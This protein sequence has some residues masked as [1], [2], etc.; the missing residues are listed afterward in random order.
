MR[1]FM[2]PCLERELPKILAVAQPWMASHQMPMMLLHW[3]IVLLGWAGSLIISYLGYYAGP[4]LFPRAFARGKP[5]MRLNFAHQSVSFAHAI[6]A[7]GFSL[8]NMWWAERLANPVTGYSATLGAQCAVTVGYFLWDLFSTAA[9]LDYYGPAFMLHAIIG[10]FP[11][12]VALSPVLIGFVPGFLM[13]EVSSLFLH[14][15]WF[16]DKLGIGDRWLLKLNDAL[17]LVSFF[18]CRILFGWKLIIDVVKAMTQNR[19]AVGRL[20]FP[21]LCFTLTSSMTLNHFWFYRLFKAFIKV[22]TDGKHHHHHHHHPLHEPKNIKQMSKLE[23]EFLSD[24][25]EERPRRTKKKTT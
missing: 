12:A 7:S 6:I 3:H 24:G 16:I 17:L 23:Q 14:S 4:H 5:T 11:L 20:F 10:F 1:L 15:H 21:F 22:V 9:N 19:E 13:F 25:H 8:Y 2:Q 18:A